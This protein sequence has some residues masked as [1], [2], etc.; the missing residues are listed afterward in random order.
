MTKVELLAAGSVEKNVMGSHS[1]LLLCHHLVLFLGLEVHDLSYLF[2]F[3]SFLS[4]LF[5]GSIRTHRNNLLAIRPMLGIAMLCHVH[6][7]NSLHSNSLS[8]FLAIHSESNNAHLLQGD[9]FLFSFSFTFSFGSR[10][11]KSSALSSFSFS[12]SSFSFSFSCS[13][14]LE[15]S[16]KPSIVIV[17]PDPKY[18]F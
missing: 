13:S 12:F 8:H 2:L 4:F 1:L 9:S 15:S 3:L 6:R 17:I 5:L 11:E 7:P 18:I 14:S 16:L 10:S